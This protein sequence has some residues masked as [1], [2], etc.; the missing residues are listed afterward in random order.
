MQV[1]R[2]I[3]QE[4][5][6]SCTATSQKAREKPQSINRSSLGPPWSQ[7]KTA[8]RVEIDEISLSEKFRKIDPNPFSSQQ[9]G[10]VF[11]PTVLTTPRQKLHQWLSNDFNTVS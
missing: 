9:L 3:F 1:I 4:S 8:G 11:R 5:W 2:N 7:V 6:T 10:P